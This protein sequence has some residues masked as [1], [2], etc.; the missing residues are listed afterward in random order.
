MG[1]KN[2]IALKEGLRTVNW[3]QQVRNVFRWRNL[4]AFCVSWQFHCRN[5][6]ENF[7][8]DSGCNWKL[9][10]IYFTNSFTLITLIW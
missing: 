6:L 3:T 1:C 9:Y 8:G 7:M 2:C 5:E 4:R 10:M